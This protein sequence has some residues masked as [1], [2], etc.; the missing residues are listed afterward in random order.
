MMVPIPTDKSRDASRK[1]AGGAEMIGKKLLHYEVVARLGAG[2]MGE[3]WR[4][5]DPRLERDV[6]IKIL[7]SGGAAEPTERERFVREARAASALAHPN[8]ITI[9]EINTADGFDFIVMEYVRGEALSAQLSRGPLPVMR[10]VEYAVQV[11]DALNAAHEAGIVHRDLKPGNIMVAPSG[12]I[13]VVDFGIAKRVSA[14]TTADVDTTA[15]ALTAMG[16]SIGTPS[17]MS[18]EQALGDTVDGRSDLFSFGIVLYEMLAGQLPFQSATRLGI[19][20]QIVH[21]PPRPLALA[22][23]HVP[24][25]LAAVVERC[26]AKDPAARYASAASLRDDLRRCAAQ[27]TSYVDPSGAETGASAAPAAA[28]PRRA[29]S[30]RGAAIA[31]GLLLVVAVVW[32]AGPSLVQRL[33]TRLAPQGASATAAASPQELYTRA[34][35]Q[36]RTY[37]REGSIDTAIEQLERALTLRSPYPIAEARLS[38]A[39]WRRNSISADPEWQ[40]RALA[41]AERAVQDNDQLAMA[42]IARGAAFVIAGKLA[43]A[44]EA[45]QKAETLEPANWELLWRLGALAVD[46]KDPVAAE[47]YFR[48]ATQVAP[49]EWEP[50]AR[51]GNFLYQQGRY[52]DAIA[53]YDTMRELARDHTRAYSNL[54]AAYHQ[55]GRTDEAAAVLQRALEIAPDGPTFSNLGTYLYFQ[56]KYPEA[57]RAFDQAIKLNA[58]AYQ[59]W[60]NLG[61]AVRMTAPG[62]AKMHDS[63]RRAIQ[64]ARGELAKRPNEPNIRSSLAL[65]LVRDGQV[66]EALAEI[67]PVLAQSGIP[68][69]VLFKGSLVAELAGQRERS[70]RLLGQALGAGYQLREIG[71]EPDLVKLRADPDY[72]RLASRY[73]K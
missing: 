11:A 4:A 33:R 56:G 51:L 30:T 8:I 39:Y 28:R 41:H 9:H 55:L 1:S 23:P 34:T 54:A 35:E 7:P 46:R 72:H 5:V 48:R 10:A 14:G 25:E 6:A 71:A 27:L 52:A 38:L 22:A 62:S 44:S 69:S 47:Q 58:N 12:L 42:H 31:A 29:V 61:D 24:A 17:Y 67:D 68:P 64:L 2:G 19:V 73:E 53:S 70:L 36:L 57:E 66:K 60:G 15:A 32:A 50:H 18:P 13:K 65:Y 37:Y 3:V 21:E 59:R 40:K 26:L 49:S 16:V 20:R 45:Y 63:Y 43:D